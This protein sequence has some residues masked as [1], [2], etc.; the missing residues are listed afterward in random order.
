MSLCPFW[1]NDKEKVNCFNDCVFSSTEEE[2]CP[3]KL[4]LDN[5][6]TAIKDIYDYSFQEEGFVLSE[7]W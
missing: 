7:S 2:S 5:S 1:S 6:G 4:Y 3:F